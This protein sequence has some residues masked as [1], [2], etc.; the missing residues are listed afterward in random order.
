MITDPTEKCRVFVSRKTSDRKVG[1]RIRKQLEIWSPNLEFFD[2]EDIKE[3]EDWRARIRKELRSAN[4]LWLVLTK[5]AMD[6][7][8]WILYEA[9][10]FESLEEED[11]RKVVCIYADP[12]DTS[13]S[14]EIGIPSQLVYKQAVK[15]TE[16]QILKLLLRLFRDK[17][18]T[19]TIRPLNERLSEENLRPIAG[20]I[21]DAINQVDPNRVFQTEYANTYIKLHIPSDVES[22][23]PGIRVESSGKSLEQLFDLGK[24]PPGGQLWT[25]GKISEKISL[26]KDPGFNGRWTKQ[27]DKAISAMKNGDTVRQLTGK[28]LAADDKLYRPEIEIYEIYENGR[29]T[30]DVTFSHQV[31]DSWL[32]EAHAPVALA[33]NL[34]LAS[35]I[36][37][38]VMEP[39]LRKLP[40]WRTEEAKKEGCGELS[41]LVKQ[42]E[43]DGYFIR[44][45][46]ESRLQEAFDEAETK[47]LAD[48]ETGYAKEIRPFL[49][50][51][52]R[53]REVTELGQVLQCWEKNNL[54]FLRIALHRYE[55]MLPKASKPRLAAAA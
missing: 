29:L 18:F 23:V 21:A 37:H 26:D 1:A 50:K 40:L 15:A 10:L 33:A 47:E 51:A 2:A 8:D 30:V 35:R 46:T 16:R 20:T 39:Y 3:S 11:R 6:N 19:N 53:D 25:W 17:E 28:F 44:R 45:L 27:L 38:E 31:Q 42:I 22:L 52:L 54:Q 41:R 48:L 32:Q 12:G 24:S 49:E 43:H 4:L 14:A 34:A 9:G 36:R 7:F 13:T 5:P 55:A